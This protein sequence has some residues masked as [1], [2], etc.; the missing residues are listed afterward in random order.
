[1]KLSSLFALVVAIAAMS[2]TS[3][4]DNESVI[5]PDIYL[6]LDKETINANAAGGSQTITVTASVAWSASS[7]AEWVTISPTTG[8]GDGTISVQIANNPDVTSRTGTITVTGEGVESQK[9][10][11]SQAAAEPY[12]TITDNFP[13][14]VPAE[15]G[16]YKVT[17]TSN[18][19]W[20]ADV[21]P[22]D[23]CTISP[24]NGSS[25]G[26]ITVIIAENTNFTER[27]AEIA[28]TAEGVEAQ[29][30]TLTQA[31]VVFASGTWAYSNIYLNADG[32]PTFE[33]YPD[34]GK[35]DYQGIYFRWG[36]LFGIS[37]DDTNATQPYL[38]F[39][40]NGYTGTIPTQYGDV[41]Y[42]N[43]STTDLSDYDAETGIGDICRYITTKGWVSGKWRMP[44]PA[45]YQTLIDAGAEEIGTF[46]DITGTNADGTTAIGSG[47]YLGI[48]AARRF[49]PASGFRHNG[50][51]Y[52][53]GRTGQYWTTT[54]GTNTT[55][56]Y[57][58]SLD[59]DG[60][61]YYNNIMIR[62]YALSIRCVAE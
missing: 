37:A 5:E 32:N 58:F 16:T 28:V 59:A 47:Y 40:P 14:E 33:T 54:P 52:F 42:D 20:S 2:I 19:Q 49:F 55:S 51:I 1:M 61:I 34:S 26:E 18:I 57:K 62:T 45:E 60:A 53:H 41:P 29:T 3:C 25:N 22:T 11:V 23:W 15:G 13:D 4:K 24:A 21:L 7:D 10:A 6:N 8:T 46:D 48:G 44:T 39:S 43:V 35:E 12:L 36:S 31:A 30:A 56:A 9:V 27:S 38:V 17:V 50:T